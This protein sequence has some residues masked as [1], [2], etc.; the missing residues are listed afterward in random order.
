M[1][2]SIK[3]QST[4]SGRQW[5]KGK[6][7][8]TFPSGRG[9]GTQIMEVRCVH[10]RL[11]LEMNELKL[12]LPIRV[13]TVPMKML[14]P[15]GISEEKKGQPEGPRCGALGGLMRH[16]LAGQPDGDRVLWDPLTALP[17]SVLSSPS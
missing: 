6:E 15:G 14:A 9:D 13:R 8:P 3:A 10:L 5:T 17:L 2:P 4:D 1:W 7:A 12:E 11:R 16:A